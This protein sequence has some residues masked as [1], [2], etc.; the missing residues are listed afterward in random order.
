MSGTKEGSSR[1]IAIEENVVEFDISDTLKTYAAFI[2][3]LIV[4]SDKV[5]LESSLA[6]KAFFFN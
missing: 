6:S 5:A 4:F 3:S 1:V 2:T